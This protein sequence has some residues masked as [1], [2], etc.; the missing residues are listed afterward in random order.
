[1]F[2]S[3]I[4]LVSGGHAA[5][6]VLKLSQNGVYASHQ[7]LWQLFTEQ[8]ERNFLFREELGAGGLPQFYVL[9]QTAPVTDSPMFQVQSKSFQPKLTKGSRLAFQLRANPT[10][11]VKNTQGKSQR[12]DVLMHTK[13]KLMKDGRKDPEQTQYLMH[14]AAQLWLADPDR[15][16]RFGFTVDALPDVECYTQHK[17]Q[18]K[19]H[20]VQFSSVDYQGVLTVD[21]PDI[22]LR[23]YSAGY[24][25]AKSMGC[26]LMLIR[27]V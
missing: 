16:Q 4:S 13:R 15:L 17:S 9:S 23:Q 12:H 18:K 11:C 1:M 22:F 25:R 8:A 5:G 10:V 21:N 26:G 27:P 20:T 14:E 7:L 3:K 6:E 19:N 2:L 24:G